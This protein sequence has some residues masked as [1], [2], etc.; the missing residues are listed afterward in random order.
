MSTPQY[1]DVSVFNGSID[2]AAYKAWATSFDGI[3][4]VAMRSSYGTGY[5]DAKFEEYRAGA[6][7]AGIDIIIYYHYAYPELNQAAQEANWQHQ[8]VGNIREQDLLMLDYEENTQTAT[9]Q[10]AL[11]WLATQEQNYAGRL[12]IIYAADSYITQHLQDPRLA[13]FPLVLADWQFTPN[14]RPACPAPWS[15]YSYLQYTDRAT[16]IPGI[17]GAM[18]A[19]IYLGT[20]TIDMQQVSIDISNPAVAEYFTQVDAEHWQDKKSGNIIQFGDLAFYKSFGN[21]AL[22]GLTFLGLPTSNEI[23]LDANGATIQHY[24]R[25]DL[26]YDPQHAHDNP[27]GSGS[28][29]LGNIDRSLA[30]RVA[31]A[32]ADIQAAAALIGDTATH[33]LNTSDQLK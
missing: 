16:N 14:E 27:P 21:A 22:C 6:L 11:E 2:W 33:I 29:Y 9:A 31:A 13:R 19:N 4:R 7:A 17:P 3:S 8:V 26:I 23:P 30:Q 25:A 28:I 10:W 32:R 1:V 15:S 5:I 24:E 12:P 20:E 18:D